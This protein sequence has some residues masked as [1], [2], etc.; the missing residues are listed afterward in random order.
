M[1]LTVA[2]LVIAVALDSGADLVLVLIVGPVVFM[3]MVAVLIGASD[4]LPSLIRITAVKPVRL[5]VGSLTIAVAFLA[6][7]SI[8]IVVIGPDLRT[9]G[10]HGVLAPRMLGF[11]AQPVHAIDVDGAREP[12][13]VLYLGGNADLYVLVDP[14]EPQ[15]VEY[16][17]VGSTRLIVIDEVA[18]ED[19][20]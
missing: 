7:V 4:D 10:V 12:R 8:E 13:D 14:C 11:G 3:S 19:N 18:C 1:A 15:T 6:V 9:D 17:S 2:W 5:I 20:G 16:V